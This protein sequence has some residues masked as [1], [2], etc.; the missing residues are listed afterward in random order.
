MRKVGRVAVKALRI[1]T[2]RE[3]EQYR[4]RP[5]GKCKMAEDKA[6]KCSLQNLC[7]ASTRLQTPYK[8]NQ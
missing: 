7:T 2:S 3:F 5:L 8:I 4:L 6:V 1:T